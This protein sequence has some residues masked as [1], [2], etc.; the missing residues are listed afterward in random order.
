MNEKQ[1]TT[2]VEQTETNTETQDVQAQLAAAVKAQETAAKQVE[3]LREAAVKNLKAERDNLQKRISEIDN[4]LKG[5]GIK[6]SKRGRKP[7]KNAKKAEGE[8]SAR[9]RGRGSENTLRDAVQKILKGKEKGMRI[10]EIVEAL[11]KA[12][13]QTDAKDLYPM[14]AQTVAEDAFKR[15]ERGIYANK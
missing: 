11:E 12:N 8:K 14:V 4:E 1:E 7:R 3:Q 2:V 5:F 6:T 15:L 10:T 9:F 13:Y